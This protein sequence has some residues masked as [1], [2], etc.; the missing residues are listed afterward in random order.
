MHNKYNCSKRIDNIIAAHRVMLLQTMTHHKANKLFQ[1][2]T[3]QHLEICFVTYVTQSM[4]YMSCLCAVYC[5]TALGIQKC[6]YNRAVRTIPMYANYIIWDLI[7]KKLQEKN[8]QST[9]IY[10]IT[11]VVVYASPHYGKKCFHSKLYE[12]CT[13]SGSITSCYSGR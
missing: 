11:V 10:E 6:I 4:G 7:T 8:Y 9:P 5:I 13:L 12:T 3:L 1:Q 2:S